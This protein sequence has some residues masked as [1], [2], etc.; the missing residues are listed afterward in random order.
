MRLLSGQGAWLLQRITAVYAGLFV[1]VVLAY[2]LIAPPADHAAWVAVIAHPAVAL[3]SALFVVLLLLHAWI[4]LRDIV[5]DYVKPMALRLT[6]LTLGAGA[7]I[8]LG[9][10]ALYL[11]IRTGLA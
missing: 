7:L 4:G 5:L 3:G 9:L 6:V 2:F 1:I 8:L 10:W 11:L